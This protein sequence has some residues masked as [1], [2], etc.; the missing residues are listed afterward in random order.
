MNFL[1]CWLLV[2]F[3]LLSFRGDRLM[4]SAQDDL[5]LPHL[6]SVNKQSNSFP[7]EV[8]EDENPR[9]PLPLASISYSCAVQ[10][11]TC[12]TTTDRYYEI[13]ASYEKYWI[14]NYPPGLD[15]PAS[16]TGAYARIRT[17]TGGEGFED[18]PEAKAQTGPLGPSLKVKP[19]ETMSILLRNNLEPGTPPT[20][21]GDGY[22]VESVDKSLYVPFLNRSNPDG[23]YYELQP[24]GLTFIGPTPETVED[25]T[26]P[27]PENIPSNYDQVN[28]HL[29]GAVV[30]PHL[31][32]P[33]GTSDADA[34]WISVG[35]G[36]C[37]C[38]SFY[39]PEDHPTGTYWYHTHRHGSSAMWTWAQA[40]GLL[41]I[42][43]SF[44]RELEEAGISTV[45]PFVVTDPHFAFSDVEA[46]TY[47]VTTFLNGQRGIVAHPEATYCVN[48]QFQPNFEM[49][50]GETTWLK[51]LTGTTENL[52]N[53]RILDE[54]GNLVKVWDAGSDGINYAEPIQVDQYVQGGGMRQDILLQF[55]AAGIYEVWT[56]GLSKIQFYGV[57]PG[58]QLLAT[59]QVTEPPTPAT[60]VDISSLK[61][62]LPT[63]HAFNIAPETVTK[64]RTVYF[65]V[66]GDVT[67]IPFPQFTIN[68]KAFEIDYILDEL[69]LDGHAE[70]WTLVSTS[71]ATHPFHI[72]VVPF[73]VISAS[74]GNALVSA[75]MMEYM[76][77]VQPARVWRDT[78]VI[79]PYGIVKIWIQFVPA[80][81][82]NLNGK[83]VFHCHFLAHE[84][85][86]MIMAIKFKDV[87]E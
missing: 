28:L 26:V 25:I 71:N 69:V 8:S 66:A 9:H 77:R 53:F 3:L 34:D 6:R 5:D 43:G 68:E 45:T 80:P 38:Y 23:G 70:E 56:M 24:Y 84:D 82:V 57:G 81:V 55:P 49:T 74:S 40:A 58:D 22:T 78:V 32:M 72:H 85:T 36:E 2:S 62:T 29:H 52:V 41:A 10:E 4:I 63:A 16:A 73:Q 21:M 12:G 19:G 7:E 39:F 37:Y 46:N 44:S 11:R 30:E 15:A 61:F 1:R 59:F 65:D 17:F 54:D 86:G 13:I 18:T 50:V 31:F 27:N 47:V 75:P 14:E 42:E 79:P 60:A 51:F 35:P 76:T 87:N 33:Q 20:G 67:K 64:R 48:G 83:S